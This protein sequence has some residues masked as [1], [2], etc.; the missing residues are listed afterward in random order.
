MY[1]QTILSCLSEH[2]EFS[3]FISEIKQVYPF[4]M[5]SNPAEL[6]V[7]CFPGIAAL[8]RKEALLK[9]L[10]VH[11]QNRNKKHLKNNVGSTGELS[12]LTNDEILENLKQSPKPLLVIKEFLDWIASHCTKQNINKFTQLLEMLCV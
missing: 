11:V 6:I 12:Q 5:D 7:E 8:G 9:E 1:R 10:S 2:P 3:Q 4:L